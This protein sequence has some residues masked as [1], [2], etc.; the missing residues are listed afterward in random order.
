MKWYLVEILRLCLAT[1]CMVLLLLPVGHLLKTA[2]PL[3]GLVETVALGIVVY[4]MVV[5][6]LAR[7]S[8]VHAWLLIREG[9][10]P[11]EQE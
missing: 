3:G 7:R 10:A 2:S 11:K 1:G 8:L 9:L 5:A 4:T 6:L